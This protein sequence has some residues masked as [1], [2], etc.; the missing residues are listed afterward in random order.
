MVYADKTWVQTRIN[1]YSDDL[2]EGLITQGLGSA[3]VTINTKLKKELRNFTMPTTVPTE[4]VMAAN[5]YAASDI[6]DV[7][8]ENEENRSAAAKTYESKADSYLESY[9]DGYLEQNPTSNEGARISIMSFH[10]VDSLTNLD[11]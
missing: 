2:T 9:I 7:L 10:P 4:I 6:L 3:D 5:Y 11:S 1:G 8:F